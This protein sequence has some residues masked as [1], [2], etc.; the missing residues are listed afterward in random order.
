ML[1]AIETCF[2]GYRFR[3]RLEARWAVFFKTLK[4][5]FEYEKEGFNLGRSGYYLPDFYLP[6]QKCWIEIKPNGKAVVDYYDPRYCVLA[7]E[8]ATPV[9]VV[10]GNPWPGEYEIYTFAL[11]GKTVHAWLVAPSV[12]ALGENP[13]EVWIMRHDGAAVC[14]NPMNSVGRSYPDIRHPGLMRAYT[15]ARSARFEH[16][17]HGR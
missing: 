17:E 16:G 13:Q 2:D 15:A 1:K 9:L 5:P 10:A 12:F 4:V 8:S 7:G 3:S 11:L 14:F 6:N